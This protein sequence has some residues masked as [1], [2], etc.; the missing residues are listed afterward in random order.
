MK[1]RQKYT[2]IICI[3]LLLLAAVVILAIFFDKFNQA[4]TPAP[5]PTVLT[6]ETDGTTEDT[7]GTTQPSTEPTTEV[8]IPQE[9]TE[10]TEPPKPTQPKPTT[11]PTVPE[12]TETEPELTDPNRVLTLAKTKIS[13][14]SGDLKEVSKVT[15]PKTLTVQVS[16]M[17]TEETSAQQIVD[18]V[19]E[20]LSYEQ[21]KANPNV[22]VGNPN[23][24]TYE[25]SLLFVSTEGQKHTFQ[26]SYRFVST[27][28]NVAEQNYD[29]NR[30]VQD[31]CAYL[32][33]LG[34]VKIDSQTA[35]YTSK[36]PVIVLLEYSYDTALSIVKAQ[37][38]SASKDYRNYDFYYSAL[39]VTTKG[40]VEKEALC[41]YIVNK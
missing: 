30:L 12:T 40:G 4:D 29:T 26:F 11:K 9:T 32:N 17:Q 35:G 5:M 34:K 31:G 23:P 16:A 14:L 20:T 8:T 27:N 25:Y 7:Q 10:A 41:F 24:L 39:T 36:Q 13:A 38:E 37:V 18:K 15:N 22:A 28:Y 19:K 3:L 1:K 2:I 33:S 21:N 6:T